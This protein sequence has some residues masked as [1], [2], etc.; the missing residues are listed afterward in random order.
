MK[1][2]VLIFNPEAPRIEFKSH[3]EKLLPSISHE[4]NPPLSSPVANNNPE[5]LEKI[6]KFSDKIA[7]PTPFR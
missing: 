6:E 2:G 3:E 1:G 7:N 4:W 5:V